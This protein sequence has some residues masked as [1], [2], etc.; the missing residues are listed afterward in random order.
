[1]EVGCSTLDSELRQVVSCDS[2]GQVSRNHATTLHAALSHA[3][4]GDPTV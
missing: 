1:M 2:D 3:A 4:S